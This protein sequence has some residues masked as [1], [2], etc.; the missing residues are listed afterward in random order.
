MEYLVH[1]FQNMYTPEK[2]LPIDEEL[3]LFK[4]ISIKPWCISN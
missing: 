1:R 4:G 3:L 2:N